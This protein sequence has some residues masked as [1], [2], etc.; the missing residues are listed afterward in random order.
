MFSAFIHLPY[1]VLG[2]LEMPVNL[3]NIEGQKEFLIIE[4]LVSITS[5]ISQT[6]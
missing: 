2:M 5:R 4:T 3:T 1:R 6:A